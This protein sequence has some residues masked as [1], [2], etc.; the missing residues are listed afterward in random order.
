MPSRALVQKLFHLLVVG[1]CVVRIADG[2]RGQG[3]RPGLF[4]GVGVSYES[5]RSL[6]FERFEAYWQRGLPYLDGVVI[7]IVES[8]FSRKL[9]FLSSEGHVLYGVLPGDITTL[10]D[11]EAT[12]AHRPTAL[13]TLA[14]NSGDTDSPTADIRVR[15]AITYAIDV[16]V[17]VD[18]V[19]LGTSPP[20]NQLAS[21]DGGHRGGPG[22]S[23][24]P[25]PI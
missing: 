3:A 1:H 16:S 19:Y 2:R 13:F 9:G 10:E 17:I 25:G 24:L 5:G 11:A 4:V 18:G 20:T 21:K 7:K 12:I 14:G 8:S 22:P 15:R 23:V 6:E